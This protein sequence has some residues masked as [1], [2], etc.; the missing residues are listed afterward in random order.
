[1][2]PTAADTLSHVRF[3]AERLVAY[4]VAL[5]VLR[6][7]KR[8]SEG[9]RGWGELKAQARD[10]ALSAFLNVAEG[11][12]MPPGSRRKLRHYDIAQGSTGE[13]AAAMDAA[14]AVEL[15]RVDRRLIAR[16][17][18]LIGGLTRSWR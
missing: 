12:S 8:V 6:E 4:E 16:L 9:W 10:A 1:M 11:G 3:P 7:T 14:E 15:E 2:K 17:A 5:E 18:L 13:V